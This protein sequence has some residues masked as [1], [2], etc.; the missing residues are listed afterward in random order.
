[1]HQQLYS[2]INNSF[3]VVNIDNI[4]FDINCGEYLSS[5]KIWKE[6]FLKRWDKILYLLRQL[7][8][9]L[10]SLKTNACCKGKRHMGNCKTKIT[11]VLKTLWTE[12]AMYVVWVS[13]LW[14]TIQ[15]WW[16]K[17]RSSKRLLR[18]AARAL[19]RSLFLLWSVSTHLLETGWLTVIGWT[20]VS[21][22]IISN[23]IENGVLTSFNENLFCI[24]SWGKTKMW[25]SLNNKSYASNSCNKHFGGTLWHHSLIF[26][27]EPCK[28]K[29][30]NLKIE[31][32]FNQC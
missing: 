15:K 32:F 18:W 11:M 6:I 29:H 17:A 16:C 13:K 14:A 7:L 3:R 4:I 10:L 9:I 20:L 28:Y 2:W 26:C 19:R 31:W 1:M 30:K 5:K 25:E 22:T 21:Q 12:L 8:R 23:I 24:S 27:P